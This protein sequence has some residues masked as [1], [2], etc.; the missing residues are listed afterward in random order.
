M[1]IP[2]FEDFK[3]NLTPKQIFMMGSFGNTYFRPIYSTLNDKEYKERYK[4]YE[5]LD[6]VPEDKMNKP[7]EEYDKQSNKYKVKVGVD[8]KNNCGLEYWEDR[9]EKGVVESWI[10]SEAPYGWVEWYIRLYEGKRS[11]KYDEFQIKRWL[12][13]AGPKGRFR[14]RLIKMIMEKNGDY[15]DFTIS[16]A[17]RQTL[18]HWAYKLTKKDYEDGVKY[19]R[20]RDKL[21]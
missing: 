2:V 9:S 1:S 15:N 19:I 20:K 17:I 13:V 18:Q 14:L 8:M 7:C 3:P 10:I 12:G 11:K 4:M 16:P 5:C 21:S 6:D